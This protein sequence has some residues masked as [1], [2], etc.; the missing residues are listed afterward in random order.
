MYIISFKKNQNS[1]VAQQV[2]YPALSLK[3]LGSLLWCRFDPWP[4][5]VPHATGMGKNKQRNKPQGSRTHPHEEKMS[6]NSLLF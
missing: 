1:H 6:P 5:K 4:Q 3:W 2:K